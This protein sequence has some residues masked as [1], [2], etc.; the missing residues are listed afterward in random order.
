MKR[1]MLDVIGWGLGY[2]FGFITDEA[3]NDE[4]YIVVV[5]LA[6][7]AMMYGGFVLFDYLISKKGSKRILIYSAA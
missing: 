1:V 2:L 5:A 6:M 4:K 7:G 3:V